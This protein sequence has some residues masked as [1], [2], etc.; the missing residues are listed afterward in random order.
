MKFYYTFSTIF[1]LLLLLGCDSESRENSRAYVEGNLTG[2]T[3]NLSKMTVKIMSA[4]RN[5]AEVIPNNSGQFVI[6]GPLI[7]DAFSLKLNK[8]IK[9][10]STSKA[11]CTLSSDSLEIIVPAGITYIIFDNIEMK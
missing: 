1:L 7:S 3:I 5:V 9:S 4:E 11:G 8:K 6:S 10:F 2:N